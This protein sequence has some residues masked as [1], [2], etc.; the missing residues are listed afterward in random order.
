MFGPECREPKVAGLLTVKDFAAVSG[1]FGTRSTVS[2]AGLYRAA[3]SGTTF[4]L[5]DVK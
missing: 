4:G 3:L 1:V 5:L 2:V